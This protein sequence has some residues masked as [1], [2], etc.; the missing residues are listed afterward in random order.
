MKTWNCLYR[1]PGGPLPLLDKKK[2]NEINSCVFYFA[3]G[4]EMNKLKKNK[5]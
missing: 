1:P 5:I 4:Y 3:V 2:I